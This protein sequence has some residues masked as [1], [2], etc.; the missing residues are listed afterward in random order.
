[1]NLSVND[2]RRLQQGDLH[3]FDLVYKLYSQRLYGFAYSILKNHED[4]KEI[5]QET[6]LKLWKN[7]KQLRSDQ[8]PK[9]FLFKISYN[10][11]ID[12]IRRRLKNDQY[13][14]Y[15]K[16]HFS[17]ND[18]AA[19]NIADYNELSDALKKIIA[20]FPEQ[21]QRIFRMSREEGLSHA[22]I[23]DKLGIT[24]KT[25]ENHINLALKTMRKK[26]SGGSYVA[27]LFSVFF[28]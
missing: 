14:E 10:I 20:E 2:I 22:E 1:M 16:G 24:P 15:L 17:D 18:E 27:Q 13:L 25:V 19:E 11:S 9:A 4:A 5:V 12:L 7:R 6:F 3:A 23:A 28:F 26:L 21:R 8:S